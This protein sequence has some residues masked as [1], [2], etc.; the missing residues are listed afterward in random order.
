MWRGGKSWVFGAALSESFAAWSVHGYENG[1]APPNV[2]CRL[3]CCFRAGWRGQSVVRGWRGSVAAASSLAS[4]GGCP[5][6]LRSRIDDALGPTG[7]LSTRG[8]IA[9][10]R[11]PGQRRDLRPRA[12]EGVLVVDQHNFS[13]LLAPRRRKWTNRCAEHGDHALMRVL[14]RMCTKCG[15]V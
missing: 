14:K 1:G 10:R 9:S 6:E 7:V 2:P 15:W 3:G 8:A 4:S 5:E 11:E 12:R 13:A